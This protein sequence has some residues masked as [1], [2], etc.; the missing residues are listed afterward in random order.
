MHTTHTTHTQ[1][2]LE[3]AC[4]AAAERADN[5]FRQLLLSQQQEG[6]ISAGSTWSAAKAQ[7]GLWLGDG[8]A[9][10][11]TATQYSLLAL[12]VVCL[13]SCSG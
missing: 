4:K 10:A 3:R 8:H 13:Q 11:Q 6:A 12:S 2:V 9:A 1:V 7:V 5:D